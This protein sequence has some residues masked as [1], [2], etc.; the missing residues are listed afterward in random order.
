MS[1]HVVPKKVYFFVFAILMVF[2]A[3]T[4]FAAY[5]DL[6]QMN[7]VVAITIAVIKATL[8]VLFFMHVR[9]SDRLTW[10]V[11][12]TSFAWLALMLVLTLSDY[13]ARAWLSA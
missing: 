10:I 5:K 9:Y 3:L 1:T 4:V 8:V 12:I 13:F 7:V 11:V 6:G 2:T